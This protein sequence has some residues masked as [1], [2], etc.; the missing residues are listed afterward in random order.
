MYLLIVF[1]S[2]LGSSVAGFFERFLGNG[3]VAN[4]SIEFLL[5]LFLWICF[6]ILLFRRTKRFYL[7]I[8]IYFLVVVFCS[9]CRILFFG[10]FLETAVT[11]GFMLYMNNGEGQQPPHVP[12]GH[13]DIPVVRSLGLESNIQMRV[14]DLEAANSPFLPQDTGGEFWDNIRVNF[15]TAPNQIEYNRRL[16]FEDID[17]AVRTNKQFTLIFFKE[18][19]NN[20]ENP[21]PRLNA[22]NTIKDFYNA[23]ELGNGI[24]LPTNEE[25]L[26]FVQQVNNDLVQHGAQS[27][28]Y[29]TI[30][31]QHGHWDS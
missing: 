12:V 19:L 11:T 30:I 10:P 15:E 25:E 21:I 18:I 14:A 22:I 6:F 4:H 29:Q 24:L 23:Y 27:P 31:Y 28:Y 8:V 1:L 9:L 2:F 20:L 17:L 7:F 5:L 13:A 26:H 16:N 3:F